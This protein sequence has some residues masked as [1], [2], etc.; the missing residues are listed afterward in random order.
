MQEMLFHTPW[1]LPALIAGVGIVVF[2]SGNRRTESRVRIAG[3]GAIFLAIVLAAVSYFVDTPLETTERKSN[4]LVKAFEKADWA[5][6]S[7][8]LD[9]SAVVKV[10]DR[11]VYTS[12]ED[13]IEAAKEAHQ[14]YG[15]RSARVLSS[16]ATQ[17][18]T[19]ITVDLTLL[20]EQ[21]ALGRTLNSRWE[22]VWQKT[23]DGWMLVEVRAV[24]IGNVTGTDM[25]SMFP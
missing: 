21:D 6:M 5:K 16:S 22:F 7:S 12:R 2:I 14:R 4:E 13:T 3:L 18:D 19:I 20:T 25:R 15:F 8:V 17:A 24:Q 1:W 10:L 9:R 11:N 23:A